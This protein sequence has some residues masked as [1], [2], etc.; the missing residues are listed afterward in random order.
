MT[1][2][3]VSSR[4]PPLSSAILAHIAADW[5]GF[6]EIRSTAHAVSQKSRLTNTLSIAVNEVLVALA[7]ALLSTGRMASSA[8]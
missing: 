1:Q 7:A 6:A 5:D 8:T 4:N 2:V 3:S